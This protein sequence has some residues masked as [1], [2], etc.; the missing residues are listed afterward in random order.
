MD[1]GAD[2]PSPQATALFRAETARAAFIR[3]SIE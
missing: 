1:H 2:V 3:E